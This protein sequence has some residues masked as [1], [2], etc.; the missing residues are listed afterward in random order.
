MADRDISPDKEIDEACKVFITNIEGSQSE[1]A[2]QDELRRLFQPIGRVTKLNVKK[3]KNGLYY[4]AFLEYAHPQ[5][6]ANAIK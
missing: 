3:N 2:V 4:F 6:A 1:D 5:D